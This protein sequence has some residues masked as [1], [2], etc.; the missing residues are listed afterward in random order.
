M[1]KLKL[2]LSVWD[3]VVFITKLPL[4]TIAPSSFIVNYP[5]TYGAK[6]VFYSKAPFVPTG[7]SPIG[8]INLLFGHVEPESNDFEILK[9]VRLLTPTPRNC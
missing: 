5:S 8:P 7:L 9:I 1:F 2:P 3:E 4:P 6:A